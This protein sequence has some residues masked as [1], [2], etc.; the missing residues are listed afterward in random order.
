MVALA[1]LAATMARL[2]ATEQPV[3]VARQVA[4][5]RTP[6]PAVGPITEQQQDQ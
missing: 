2:A 4:R 1:V 3:L 5:W 6:A